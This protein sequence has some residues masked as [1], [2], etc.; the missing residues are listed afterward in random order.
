MMSGLA[1]HATLLARNVAVQFDFAPGLR[2]KAP[3]VLLS[4]AN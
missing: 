1:S 3:D 4:L 2:L